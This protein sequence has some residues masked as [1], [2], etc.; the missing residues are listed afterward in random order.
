MEGF[1]I[2]FSDF[3]NPPI[4]RMILYYGLGNLSSRT[5][6]NI[7]AS[8]FIFLTRLAYHLYRAFSF[9]RLIDGFLC[10]VLPTKDEYKDDHQFFSPFLFSF[11]CQR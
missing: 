8:F 10:L 5:L 3:I 6:F 2:L 9:T 1:N 11:R 7:Y 4:G